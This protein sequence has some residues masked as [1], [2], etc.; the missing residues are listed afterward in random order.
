MNLGVFTLL[1]RLSIFRLSFSSSESYSLLGRGCSL[2]GVAV[3]PTLAMV[4]VVVVSG[5]AA[6]AV[7]FTLYQTPLAEES[8]LCT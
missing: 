5:G 1:C 2:P 4:V 7:S 8:S 3:L 6:A